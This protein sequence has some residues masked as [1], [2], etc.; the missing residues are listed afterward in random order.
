[1]PLTDKEIRALKP[2]ESNYKRFDSQGLFLLV[3]PAGGRLW[4]WKYRFGGRE[5]LLALGKYPTVTLADARLRR[6]EARRSL[7]NGDD[8]GALKKQEKTKAE[9]TFEAVA[10]A[11]LESFQAGMKPKT[12]GLIK[13]RL[14][15]NAFPAFGSKPIHEVT[16]QEVLGMAKR[17]EARGT[18]ETARRT[19]QVVRRILDN[20]VIQG[21]VPYNVASGLSR[22]LPR[23]QV[24]HY[25]AI[26]DTRE[27][28]PL[29]RA[30]D[31]F[32]GSYVVRCALKLQP[33]TFVR[34]GELR[35]AEWGEINLDKA[36]WRIPGSRMK[37][38]R[39]HI[40]P[41]SRQSVKI[42]Q[43]VQLVSGEGRFLFPS[44]RTN[45]RPMSENTIN[46]ALRRL[47]YAKD[48]MTSHGFRSMASTVLHE[49]GWASD[50][51]ERQLAHV[52]KNRVKAA[53]C[54]AEHLPER[55]RMM[56]SWADFLDGLKSGAKV[57]PIRAVSEG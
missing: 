2:K 15:R 27:I 7:A 28:G 34:P 55:R 18:L 23:P 42:L 38:G 47:G 46:A 19:L 54:H 13:S 22:A 14:E 29:L 11:W 5:K 44:I 35:F 9:N 39:P 56:Q 8:P 31:S 41:L 6:D 49:Q 25:A 30:I 45:D 40:V 50:V 4:R 32:E 10:C 43:E 51:V 24:K 33:L 12:V 53:Y 36:E 48:E 52:E 57:S 1:M 16:A 3:T 20:A 37:A 26:V 17:V 21:L